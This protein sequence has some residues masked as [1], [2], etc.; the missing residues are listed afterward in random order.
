MQLWGGLFTLFVEIVVVQEVKVLAHVLR[1][2]QLRVEM[3][4]VVQVE[5]ASDCGAECAGVGSCCEANG[6]AGC[7]TLSVQ[8]C[9][10]AT[11]PYCC[12]STWDL[13]CVG[14]SR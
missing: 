12:T 11:D 13:L 4:V 8:S 14:K 9:V 10:C 5:T 1:I 7:E 6:S 2:V 3:V